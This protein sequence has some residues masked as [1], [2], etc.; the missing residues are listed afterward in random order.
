MVEY[1]LRRIL[2]TIPVVLGILL[3][4]FVVLFLVP[5]DPAAAMAGPRASPEDLARLRAQLALDRPLPERFVAYVGRVVCGDLGTSF[6]NDN[7]SVASLIKQ[8]LPTTVTLALLAIAISAISGVTVGMLA[9]VYRGS[10]FDRLVVVM[11]VAG[12]STPIFFSGL[13]LYYLCA[14]RW[15]WLTNESVVAAGIE[16]RIFL[17]AA[18]TLGIRSGAFMARVVRASLVEVLSEDYVRTAIAK[19]LPRWRILWRHALP[20]AMV[21][22]IT[23]VALDFS[24]YLNGSVITESIFD[25]PGLGRFAMDSIIKRDYPSVQGIVLFS[26]LV[27]TG[28]NLLA[29]L[30]YA[31]FNPKVREQLAAGGGGGA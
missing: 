10:W 11:S 19:G 9:A 24:S 16:W 13:I 29:D 23:I 30:A 20:N 4:T 1:T 3:V 18:I 2:G 26:A 7:A 12:I 17:M 27:F 8:K 28:I 31:W 21:P 15:H 22:V 6:I 14:V 25:L 5:G